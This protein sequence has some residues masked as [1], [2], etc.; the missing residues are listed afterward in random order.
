MRTFHSDAI[1]GSDQAAQYQ[2]QIA[3]SLLSSGSVV[4]LRAPHRKPVQAKPGISVFGLGYVGTVSMACFSAI[5]HPVIGVDTDA[6]KVKNLKMGESP[7]IEQE[8]PELLSQACQQGLLEAMQDV[9]SAVMRTDISLVSVGTPSGPDGSCDLTCLKTVTLQIGT[10]LA[11]KSGYHLVVFRSTVPPT[12]TRQILI[13]LLEEASGKSCG[14][15]FGVAF[16]PEFLRESTA[17]DDFRHPPK[18]VIGASDARAEAM[19]MSLYATVA[20]PKITT[21]LEC[22]EFVKY[23]DNTWHALKVSFGNEVG[24]I[25][26]AAGVDSHEVMDVFLQD[27]KLNISGHYLKPGFAFGG[28]C[29]PK[30]VRGMNSLARQLEVETPVIEQINASNASHMKHA[31]SLLNGLQGQSLGIIGLTFK[32]GTD[33]LR[34]S[35]SLVLLKKL[36]MAGQ[37]VFFYD[38]CV[39]DRSVLDSDPVIN[40]ILH[41]CRCEYIEELVQRS[42]KV[43]VTHD[44]LYAVMAASLCDESQTV[45]DVVHSEQVRAVAAHYEGICW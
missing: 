36:K 29:L 31:E 44:T 9:S 18:T 21:S 34:E 13:P 27:T 12:T 30:D 14:R 16:N 33:D 23:V 19:A 7:I 39:N 17:V 26:K 37:N 22:A 28:S 43:L 38:P 25:C 40:Q 8:L 24:R 10:A 2:G 35:P 11:A 42:A 32:P 15:D 45:I 3:T 1:A 20:G 4:P 41:A 5:G 6:T